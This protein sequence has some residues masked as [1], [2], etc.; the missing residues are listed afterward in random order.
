M[1]QTLRLTPI[2]QAQR[3]DAGRVL[4]L[5]TET[6]PNSGYGF[7]DTDKSQPFTTDARLVMAIGQNETG[8]NQ[9]LVSFDP[10]DSDDPT[11]PDPGVPPGWDWKSYGKPLK[12][13]IS[14]FITLED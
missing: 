8:Q 7:K 2:A 4:L 10:S 9:Y 14:N 11:H 13:P 3:D 12:P 1:S 6:D 5:L